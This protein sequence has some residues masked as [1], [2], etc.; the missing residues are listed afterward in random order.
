MFAPLKFAEPSINAWSY[1]R[2]I[3]YLDQTLVYLDVTF[4]T[5]MTIYGVDLKKLGS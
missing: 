1:V 2:N 5:M 4:S 3:V